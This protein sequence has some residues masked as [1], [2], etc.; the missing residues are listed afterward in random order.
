MIYGVLTADAV[1]DAEQSIIIETL[2]TNLQQQQHKPSNVFL[3]NFSYN[4]AELYSSHHLHQITLI[5]AYPGIY[6]F[7]EISNKNVPNILSPSFSFHFVFIQSNN[8]V[9]PFT[10]DFNIL[11]DIEKEQF[12]RT[13]VSGKISQTV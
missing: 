13:F 9:T 2:Q 5:N 11:C 10:E 12:G 7:A 1:A 8:T 4:F 3:S 6:T